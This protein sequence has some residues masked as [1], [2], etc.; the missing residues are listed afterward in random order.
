MINQIRIKE[1]KDI[2]I[3]SNW[4]YVEP[5]NSDV[6]NQLFE[7]EFKPLDALD[8]ALIQSKKFRMY[9]R[10][11]WNNFPFLKNEYNNIIVD[12]FSTVF[13]NYKK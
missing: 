7:L 13:N 8:Y 6:K 11:Y 9:T 1:R 4:G 12:Y 2:E 5:F 10:K 3:Y